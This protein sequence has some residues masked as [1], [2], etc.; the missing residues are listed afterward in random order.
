MTPAL[1]RIITRRELRLIVPYTPQHISRLER[2]GKF[3]KRI[4]IG[5]RRVGWRLADIEAWL[6]ERSKVSEASE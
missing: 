2:D 5:A 6:N 4:R 1:P 3:P